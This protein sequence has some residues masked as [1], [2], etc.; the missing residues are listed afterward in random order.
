MTSKF[1]ISTEA[2]EL[3]VT[4]EPSGIEVTIAPGDYITVAFAEG[5]DGEMVY[6]PR[7]VMLASS[8]HS[9]GPLLAWKS[10]GTEIH[11]LS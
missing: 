7:G 8:V 5:G 3:V 1:T 2:E 9:S 6:S 11:T 4:F 10:D